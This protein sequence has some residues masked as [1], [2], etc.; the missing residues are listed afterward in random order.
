MDG[1]GGTLAYTEGDEIFISGMFKQAIGRVTGGGVEI[2]FGSIGPAGRANTSGDRIQVKAFLVRR[3]YTTQGSCDVRSR[4]IG[5]AALEAI[6]HEREQ[7][8]QRKRDAQN[9]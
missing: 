9:K 3:N 5:V 1:A 6:V 8:D 2:Q 7:E 4:A